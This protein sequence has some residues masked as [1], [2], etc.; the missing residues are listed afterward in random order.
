MNLLFDKQTNKLVAYS[1][2][3]LSDQVGYELII[4]NIEINFNDIQ[5]YSLVNDSVVYTETESHKA[6]MAEREAIPSRKELLE[7]IRELQAKVAL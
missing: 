4:A 2:N 6:L 5:G 3:D 1:P 7:M